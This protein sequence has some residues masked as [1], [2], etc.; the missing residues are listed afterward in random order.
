M[1]ECPCCLYQ[2]L[3]NQNPDYFGVVLALNTSFI[4]KMQ[5]QINQIKFFIK[6][7]D[8]CLHLKKIEFID[9]CGW[10]MASSVGIN[11]STRH[12]NLAS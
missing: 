1:I 9:V 2:K 5:E 12:C 8:Y 10:N 11:T 6:V 7:F 4:N 3:L